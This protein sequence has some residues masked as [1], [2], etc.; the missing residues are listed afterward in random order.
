MLKQCD[1]GKTMT[2]C[3]SIYQILRHECSKILV[4]APSDAAC[5]VIAKRLLPMLPERNAILRVNWW[6]RSLDSVPPVL[7]SISPMNDSGVFIIPTKKDLMEVSVVICQC[8]VAG[9][10]NVGGDSEK[11]WLENHFTHAF[12]DESSQS[13]EFESLI[14]LFNVGTQCSVILSGD[15]KQVIYIYIHSY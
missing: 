4:C 2:V 6:S 8:F 1:L 10:L 5:D 14:P 15:P 9:C 7:L 3:E 11:N 13:F 12:I